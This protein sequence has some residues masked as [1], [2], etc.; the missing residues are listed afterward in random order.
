M[1]KIDKNHIILMLLGAGVIYMVRNREKKLVGG[2]SEEFED[3]CVYPPNSSGETP[4]L[5]EFNFFGIKAHGGVWNGEVE[6]AGRTF[7]AFCAPSW[8]LRAAIII[9]RRYKDT[10]KKHNI[11]DVVYRWVNGDGAVQDAT[12]ENEAAFVANRMGVDRYAN[13]FD[14]YNKLYMLNFLRALAMHETGASEAVI[15]RYININ[16]LNKAWAILANE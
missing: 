14:P 9:L 2:G 3:N 12:W 10:Y 4:R 11:N 6:R 7:A 1:Y 5:K 15:N 13:T 16:T 8:C